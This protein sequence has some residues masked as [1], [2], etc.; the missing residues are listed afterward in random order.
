MYWGRL[1]EFALDCMSYAL[2]E[3]PFDAMT[4]VDSDQLL[5]RPGYS[6]RL[7]EV[8]AEDLGVGCLV[9]SEVRQPR[10]TGIGP[11]ADAWR[12]Q[13]SWLPYLSRFPDGEDS[14]PQW[15]FWPGTVFTAEAARRLLDLWADP[16]LR[17][18]LADSAITATEEVILPTLVA[19]SGLRN[20]TTPFR[21]DVVQFRRDYSLPQLE[22]AARQDDTFWVH[23]APRQYDHSVRA[24]VRERYGGYRYWSSRTSEGS[25]SV[26]LDSSP[27]VSC[28]MTTAGDREAVARAVEQY[29]EQ[30][31]EP[32]ELIVV[33]DGD[34]PIEDLIAN[35]PGVTY[36]PVEQRMGVTAK[37]HL[38]VA[39]ARGEVFAHW[40]DTG[41]SRRDR[42]SVQIRALLDDAADL[43]G[44]QSLMFHDPERRETWRYT[45]PRNRRMWLA[46]AS[47]CYR[48]ELWESGPFPTNHP[49]WM[50]G[51]FW[52]SR[53][54]RAVA[55]GD[56]VWIARLSKSTQ[57][58]PDRPGSW[59]QAV[60]AD[61]EEPLALEHAR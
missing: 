7:G 56:S 4:I 14:F 17:T 50:S 45:Y 12:E 61:S 31:Y 53:A 22:R 43:C 52:P 29:V 48:R 21:G 16:Q 9:T 47:L 49:D 44:L 30:D 38:A 59:W 28:L 11:A 10:I 18:L 1:H 19:L 20:R 5:I 24:W 33:N 3:L 54:R 13:A 58:D 15:T 51:F 36:V 46:D 37:R 6:R 57:P 25:W 26:A 55:I 35:L 42:L 34:Q 41:W 2:A 40:D 23:P 32:R 60:A 27:L 8:L 39:H